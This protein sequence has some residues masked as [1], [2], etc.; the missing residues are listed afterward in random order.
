M[1]QES[2][3]TKNQQTTTP[4]KTLKEEFNLLKSRLASISKQEVE[5][6]MH[7]AH[8]IPA[9]GNSPLIFKYDDSTVYYF[10]SSHLNILSN[11]EI[12]S[13][14]KLNF[15]PSQ[16]ETCF[17]DSKMEILVIKFC[18]TFL[19]AKEHV[20]SPENYD[21]LEKSEVDFMVI[22]ICREQGHKHKLS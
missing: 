13:Q 3:I 17:F 7:I 15:D 4:A 11:G 6:P 16:I 2:E 19:V 20:F 10:S 14:R 9:M 22:D 5:H 18:T 8:S 12:V 21:L 1:Q